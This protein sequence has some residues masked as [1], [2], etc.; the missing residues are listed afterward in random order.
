MKK[1]I[2]YIPM[3]VGNNLLKG[4]YISDGNSKLNTDFEVTFPIECAINGY[5]ENNEK[6]ML[7]ALMENGNAD[8]AENLNLMKSNIEKITSQKNAEVIINKVYISP[9]ETAKNH[10]ITFK[11]LIS[12]FED[13]DELYACITFGT[14][15]TPII[16]MMALNFAYKNLKNVTI[17][18][19][20]YGKVNRKHNEPVSYYIYDITALF[21]MNNIVDTLSALNAED[22]YSKIEKILLIGENDE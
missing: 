14:K 19:I 16:E 12:F 22:A 1:F 15:P 6:I 9:K 5:C 21:F 18:S 2:T 11:N 4:K 13:G 8:C 10:L 7:I 17:G 3:Q 20:V